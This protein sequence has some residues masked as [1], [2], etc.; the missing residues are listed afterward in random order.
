MA[1]DY[2]KSNEG[3]Y[4]KV[5]TPEKCQNCPELLN[6]NYGATKQNKCISCLDDEV[7]DKQWLR[8]WLIR[9]LTPQQ[10]K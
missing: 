3:L 7:K 8:K 10:V 9:R 6:E 1:F 5:K 2:E 4:V